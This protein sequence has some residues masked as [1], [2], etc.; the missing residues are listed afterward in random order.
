MTQAFNLAQFANNLN[1]AGQAAAGTSL[2]GAVP[3]ANGGTNLTTA[4]TNGQL[5]IGNGTGYAQAA[6][7]AGSNITITNGAGTISIAATAAAPSTADVMNAIA[8]Q[9]YL[10]V[11]TISAF[12]YS[13]GTANKSFANGTVS[14][15]YLFRVT[16]VG[17]GAGPNVGEGLATTTFG[18]VDGN[19]IDQTTTFTG[20]VGSQ[21]T[22]FTVVGSGTWRNIGANYV[23]SGISTTCGFTYTHMAISLWLRIS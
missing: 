21:S 22:T 4:P 3:V 12:M 10:G 5:L 1:T 11:G 18:D 17:G 2:S 15:S 16:A 7:T 8:G 19:R 14:G 9:T 6:L 13:R 23:Y 20:V